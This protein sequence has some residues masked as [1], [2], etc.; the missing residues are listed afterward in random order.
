MVQDSEIHFTPCDRAMFLVSFDAKFRGH[1]CRGSLQTNV[2]KTGVPCRKQKFDKYTAIPWKQ[3][4]IGCK[5]VLFSNRKSHMGF[6][7]VRKSVTLNDLEWSRFASWHNGYNFA[8]LQSTFKA[9]NTKLLKF[10]PLLSQTKSSPNNLV[11]DNIWFAV[12]FAEITEN[13]CITERLPL[14]KGIIWPILW[15]NWETVQD[16]M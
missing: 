1:V 7:L 14:S 6:Q 9:N 11:F 13:K 3:C 5:L 10:R 2:L 12:I 16:R 15:D 8:L 4:K